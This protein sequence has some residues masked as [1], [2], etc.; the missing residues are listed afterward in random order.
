LERGKIRYL[1]GQSLDRH[2]DFWSEDVPP[3]L[4][5]HFKLT[6]E[7]IEQCLD[8]FIEQIRRLAVETTRK[9]NLAVEEVSHYLLVGGPPQSALVQRRLKNIWPQAKELA[10]ENRQR[11]TVRGCALLAERGFELALSADIAVRQFDDCLHFVLRKGQP[12]P[13]G[14]H[15]RYREYKYRVTDFAAPQAVLEIGQIP[16]RGQYEPLEVL[17][18]PVVHQQNPDTR[19]ALPYDICLRVGLN[20]CLY[21]TAT[22]LGRIQSGTPPRYVEVHEQAELSRIPLALVPGTKRTVR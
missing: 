18:V 3:D 7:M 1:S 9:A 19:S 20:E 14:G 22:A 17:S 10:V 13:R 15:G 8:G 16:E 5:M 11:A 2:A 6:K 4:Y 21:V 12:F